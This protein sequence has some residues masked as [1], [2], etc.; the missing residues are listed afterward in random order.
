MR[1]Q[2]RTRGASEPRTQDRRLK[3]ENGDGLLTS[4]IRPPDSWIDTLESLADPNFY[5]AYNFMTHGVANGK[6]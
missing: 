1:V 6:D 2:P 5:E 3:S 4:D